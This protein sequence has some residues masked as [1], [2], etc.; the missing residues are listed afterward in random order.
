MWSTWVQSPVPHAVDNLP[1]RMVNVPQR[2]YRMRQGGGSLL[3]T[4][5]PPVYHPRRQNGASSAG[6]DRCL[7][8]AL[9][10]VGAKEKGELPLPRSSI[11][12]RSEP[13]RDVAEQDEDDQDHQHRPQ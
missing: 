3:A 13:A 5:A 1:Y 2:T 7:T 11:S 9:Q 10:F 12:A 8:K 6:R 4:Y